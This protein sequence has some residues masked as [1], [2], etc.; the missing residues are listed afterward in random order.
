[1]SAIAAHKLEVVRTLVETAPDAVLRN[2]ELALASAGAQGPLAAVRGLVEDETAERYVRNT[3]LAPIVPLCQ[4]RAEG[5][6]QFPRPALGLLW[7]A[8][9][10]EAPEKVAQARARCNPWELDVGAPDVFNQLCKIGGHGLRAQTRAEFQAVA[11][12]CDAQGLAACLDIAPIVRSA[13]PRLSEWVSRMSGERAAAARLTYNDACL[14]SEDAGPLLFEML[15]AQLPEPWRILRVI[16]AVMD[17]PSDRY[18]ASSEVKAFGERMLADIETAIETVHGFDLDGGEPAARAA[19]ASAQ[20]VA[21]QVAEFEQSVDL[22]KD[23]PWGKRLAKL[24]QAAAQAAENR[25]NGAE[26]ELGLALPLRPT[27]MMGKFGGGKGGP[28]LTEAPDAA[29]VRRAAAA[30]AFVAELRA[31]AAQAGYAGAR[32]KVLEK[33]NQRLD[34]YIEDALAAARAGDGDPK[35]IRACLDVAAGYIAHTRDEKTA[36]I[37]RRRTAAA[38]VG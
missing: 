25:M 15:S 33:L 7:I 19:A 12:I 2:L 22:A 5:L 37:V 34:Q 32:N 4:K 17:R 9:K 21:N 1:M 6:P 35:I 16:S 30:L 24:K 8:L 26:K 31:P 14:I 11:A 3:I 10:A 20:Q 23:G 13:V 36:E 28:R 27:S 18:L 38:I 29:A